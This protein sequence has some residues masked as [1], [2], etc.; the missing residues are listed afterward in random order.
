MSSTRLSQI[1]KHLTPSTQLILSSY[2]TDGRVITLTIN[3][4][5]RANCLSTPVLE[6]LLAALQSINPEITLDSTVEGEDPIR[7]AKRV[8]QSHGSRKVPKV[9]IIKA[10]GKIFSSGHDLKE[11]HN[12]NY[13]YDTIHNIFQLC[14]KVMLTIRR[15]PQVVI[16]QV[17]LISRALTEG[18]RARNSGRVS[19]SCTSRPLRCLSSSNFC[20]SR[21]PA[22]RILHHTIRRYI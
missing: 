18:P 19:I 20:H 11:F 5:V 2:S 17:C 4:A 3:N 9:V 21:R 1:Q 22:R 6:E 8:V 10:A 12:S 13:D 15:L 14:N 16:S 7:F